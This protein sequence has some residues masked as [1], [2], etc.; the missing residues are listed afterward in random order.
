[1]KKMPWRDKTTLPSNSRN[2][3]DSSLSGFLMDFML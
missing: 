1:L 2:I 3:Q